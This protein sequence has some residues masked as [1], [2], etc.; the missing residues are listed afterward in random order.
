[1]D[2]CMVVQRI[3]VGL[4][5]AACLGEM[6]QRRLGSSS[7]DHCYLPASNCGGSLTLEG[8]AML[9]THWILELVIDKWN[10]N[11]LQSQQQVRCVLYGEPANAPTRNGY[12]S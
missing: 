6:L 11:E 2:M 1:M 5:A 10:T 4:Y 7:V 3:L 9:N 12:D 8:V